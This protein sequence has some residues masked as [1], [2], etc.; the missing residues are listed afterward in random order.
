MIDARHPVTEADLRV[1]ALLDQSAVA[2]QI[3]LTKADALSAGE[4]A[5][6]SNAADLLARAH[7]A[8]HPRVIATSSREG[9]GI[10]ELRAELATLAA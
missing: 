5:Q 3:V 4:L 6:R 1:M 2:F 7:P 8:A 9:S 10:V